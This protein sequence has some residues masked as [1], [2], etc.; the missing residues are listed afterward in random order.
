MRT[1]LKNIS[2]IFALVAVVYFASHYSGTIKSEILKTFNIPG[3]SVA[4]ASTKRAQEISGKISSDIIG[5]VDVLQ[6][7][8]L[9]LTLTDAINGMS[10]LQKISRDFNTLK[11]FTEKKASDMLKSGK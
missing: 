2:L 6:K 10:R 1:V 8:S 3:S 7:Q 11:D 9:N 4:G 5:Q